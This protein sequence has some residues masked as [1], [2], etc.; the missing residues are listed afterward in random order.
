MGKFHFSHDFLH[1]F[2]AVLM[3]FGEFQGKLIRCGRPYC[4]VSVPADASTVVG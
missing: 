2:F 3:T 4:A 1:E